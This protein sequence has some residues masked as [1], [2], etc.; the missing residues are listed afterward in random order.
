[1]GTGFQAEKAYNSSLITRRSQVRILPPLLNKRSAFA[2]LLSFGAWAFGVGELASVRL[3]GDRV[4][5]LVA[6]SGR[7]GAARRSGLR[8]L[9]AAGRTSSADAW[10]GGRR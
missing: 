6:K 2:G 10:S 3:H 1:M 5:C 7:A 9:G 4:R 8:R